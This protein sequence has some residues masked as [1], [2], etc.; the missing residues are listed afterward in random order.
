MRMYTIIPYTTLLPLKKWKGA[1][2]NVYIIIVYACMVTKYILSQFTSLQL[3]ALA[4]HSHDVVFE[5]VQL[6]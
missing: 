4:F 2:H 5:L 3:I 6:M 1:I